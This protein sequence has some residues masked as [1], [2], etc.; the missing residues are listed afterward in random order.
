MKRIPEKINIPIDKELDK[1]STEKL[2]AMYKAM[3]KRNR[4]RGDMK[5]K[6][7]LNQREHIQK[8]ETIIK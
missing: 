6:A 5:I 8:G 7:I 3:R 2:L 4:G 1:L